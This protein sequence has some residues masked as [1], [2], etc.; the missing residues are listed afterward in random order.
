M[1]RNGNGSWIFSGERPSFE[2][3]SDE[4]QD[5]IINDLCH[6][7]QVKPATVW[8]PGIGYWAYCLIVG[9]YKRER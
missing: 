3:L 9:R 7:C 2:M 1:K 4:E 6:S 8:F 5:E